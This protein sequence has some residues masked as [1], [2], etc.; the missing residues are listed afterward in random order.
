[1]RKCTF[2]YRQ[3]EHRYDP[4]ALKRLNPRLDDLAD[5]DYTSQELMYEVGLRASK[6]SIQGVQPKLS[7][8]LDLKNQAF[9][10]VERKG[11]FI[12]KPPSPN[13]AN[14]PENEDCTMKLAKTVG[15]EVPQHGLVYGKDGQLTY[16]VRRFDRTAKDQRLSIEDFAQLS[17]ASRKT[18]YTSSWE[19]VAKVVEEYCSFPRV[20]FIKLFKLLLFCFL[21][22]N[23]DQHLKNFSLL[24]RDENKQLSP[25]YDQ[26]NSTIV[27]VNAQEESALP[28]AGKKSRFKKS[29]FLLYAKQRLKLTDLVISTVFKDIAVGL[30][31]WDAIIEASFLP[32]LSKQSYRDLVAERARRLGLVRMQLEPDLLQMLEHPI[33]GQGAGQ[34]FFRQLNKQRAGSLQCLTEEQLQFA[35]EQQP[36][37]WGSAYGLLVEQSR[38]FRSSAK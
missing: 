5:L 7:A 23:E 6:L 16:W 29:D 8:R 31:T 9:Q 22:G 4:S 3:V 18:K 30:V 10:L 12:L 37:S 19:R 24:E 38:P 15:L 25:C 2:S 13:Y 28:L 1:M 14:L 33:E 17:G 36:G 20:E 27:L 34:S 11:Q 35:S 26:V 21:C 32:E